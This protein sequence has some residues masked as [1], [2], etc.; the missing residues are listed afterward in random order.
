MPESGSTNTMR[1]NVHVPSRRGVGGRLAP[2]V[3]TPATSTTTM[4]M[5]CMEPPLVGAARRRARDGPGRRSNAPSLGREPRRR[6]DAAARRVDDRRRLAGDASALGPA[7]DACYALRRR[8]RRAAPLLATATSGR[9]HPGPLVNDYPSQSPWGPHGPQVS[10]PSV[11][12]NPTAPSATPDFGGWQ[13]PSSAP[14]S[15]SG[16]GGGFVGGSVGGT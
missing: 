14:A 13:A 3:S 12:P 7:P 11:M 15:F 1:S 5:R 9:P 8:F 4:S 16:G 6:E 2:I 10:V